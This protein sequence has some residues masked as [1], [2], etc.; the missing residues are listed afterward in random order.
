MTRRALLLAT[1]AFFGSTGAIAAPR[2]KIYRVKP[3]AP[4]QH[5]PDVPEQSSKVVRTIRFDADGNLE[6]TFEAA[7]KPVT[8]CRSEQNIKRKLH[9]KHRQA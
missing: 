3:R 7:T 2:R 5:A 8:R 6:P 9:V 4:K 1:C